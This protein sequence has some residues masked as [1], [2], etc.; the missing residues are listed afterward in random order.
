MSDI[1]RHLIAAQGFMEE[2]MFVDAA[3]ELEEIAT[4]ARA[5]PPGK[6]G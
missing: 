6:L 1:H 5:L 2:G 4:E 3:N